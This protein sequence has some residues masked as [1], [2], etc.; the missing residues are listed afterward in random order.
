MNNVLICPVSLRSKGGCDKFDYLCFAKNKNMKQTYHTNAVTN[1]SNRFIIKN[2]TESTESLSKRFGT[3][4]NTISKWKNRVD[5]NDKLST[6]ATIAY[7]LS[8]TQKALIKTIRMATWLPLDEIFE[9]V[10]DKD[11][12][13]TRSAVYRLFV[14]EKINRSGEPSSTARKKGKSKDF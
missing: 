6:P 12:T 3:S 11:E 10:S 7:A 13:I 9:M 8:E 2:S 4:K 14:K 1:V 5:L